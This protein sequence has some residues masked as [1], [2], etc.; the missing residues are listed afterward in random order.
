MFQNQ[1]LTV[2]ETPGHNQGSL[3]FKLQHFCFT[4]DSLI[5]GNKVVTKLKSGNKEAAKKSIFKLKTQ[6]QS[7]DSIMPGHGEP[8]SSGVVDW[9]FF[10]LTK[11]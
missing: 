1:F 6:L 2:I 4:G 9:N 11:H 10:L 3:S 5:P 7:K 8:I